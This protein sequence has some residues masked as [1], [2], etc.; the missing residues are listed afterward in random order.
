MSGDSGALEADHLPSMETL[1]T[2]LNLDYPGLEKVKEAARY[3]RYS[4]ALAELRAYFINRPVPGGFPAHADRTVIP[5]Y[6]REHCPEE[7]GLV[8][9]TADE[10]LKQTF[11]F[12]F[13]WDMERTRI[14]VVFTEK[15][16][17][18]HVPSGDVE[19]PYMLNRHRY[20]IALGQASVLT[21]GECYAE[22]LCRQIEDWIDRNPLPGDPAGSLNWRSIEAG[23]RGTNWTKAVSY[24][25]DSPFL[26]GELLCKFLL[27]LHTHAAY[28]A[29]SFNGWKNIS[30]WGVLESCGLLHIARFLPEFRQSGEWT[31]LALARMNATA[32]LQILPDGMHWEQSPTYHHEVLHCYLEMLHLCHS[33]GLRADEAATDAVHRM[34]RASLDASRPD[35]RQTMT[36]DSDSLD[37]STVIAAAALIFKDPVLRFGGGDCPGYDNAW[38]FG[39]A[40]LRQYERL[41]PELP[42]L[43]SRPFPYSGNY[44][45]RSGWDEQALFLLLRCAPLGGG[46]GHADS[47]HIDLYAYG[48]ELLTDLG[49][50]SYSNEEPLRTKLKRPSAHNTTVVD[51][52]DFT[53]ILDTWEFGHIAFPA[54]VRWISQPDFDYAEASH[55]GYRRLEDPVYPRRRILF[56]KPHCWLLIDTFDCSG[57]I[58][59]GS[60]FISLPDRSV[61]PGI[62]EY[63]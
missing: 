45:M 2:L 34:A 35:R 33:G 60:I 36:G 1:L 25:L 54:G 48:K 20:W 50:Y 8:L 55:D 12:R 49:R 29:A 40:G 56:L 52:T 11:L 17:W 38:L 57:S 7:L 4:E 16:D 39:A 18:N 42:P 63:A 3:E 61:F 44:C 24:I 31:A 10:V 59:S 5:A 46:H 53:E 32:S 21:G 27:S 6:V 14:P 23:L 62:R 19:W 43:L 26:T 22:R 47:L 58:V 15:I 13:P 9:R 28:L 51:E 37:I 30:N 41:G